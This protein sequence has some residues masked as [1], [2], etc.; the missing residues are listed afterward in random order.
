MRNVEIKAKIKDYD[1]ICKVAERLSNGPPTLI[2][3]S[4]TFYTVNTGRLKMRF[5][6]DSAA[7][8]VRYDRD[9]EIGPK[10]SNYEL[11]QFSAA[12]NDK[13]KLLDVMLQKCLGARGKVVKQRKLYM[14]GETRIHIDTVE[15]LGNFMEL[16]VVLRPEQSVEEGQ[17]IANKLQTELG[18][19]N[20][21][22]IECAYIDMLNKKL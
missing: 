5:Y 13:A 2:K 3:Q 16:E 10:C 19:N 1:K 6:E 21:D 7:T 8:L 11:L 18:V 17:E 22:L 15:N 4:D 9:D 14:V 20:E 12:E